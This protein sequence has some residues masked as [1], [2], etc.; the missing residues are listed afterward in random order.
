MEQF[1]LTFYMRSAEFRGPG[2]HHRYDESPEDFDM[3]LD[4]RT[5]SFG[6]LGGRIILLGDG[7]ELSSDSADPDS[8]MFDHDDEDLDLEAQVQRGS[9][10]ESHDHSEE[11]FRRQREGTPAPSGNPGLSNQSATS[12]EESPSSVSTERSQP[13]QA[14]DSKAEN[15]TKTES[16][17]EAKT[18][19]ASDGSVEKKE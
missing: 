11:S 13:A 15:A 8:E 12:N 1:Q 3:D 19:P 17:S 14:E 2:V 4:H 16:P 9:A 10:D 5:R 18:K 6:G 7:T